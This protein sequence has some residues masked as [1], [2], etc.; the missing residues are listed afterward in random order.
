MGQ[1]EG[2]ASRRA[3]VEILELSVPSEQYLYILI[4]YHLPAS[5]FIRKSVYPI[6]LAPA[7]LSR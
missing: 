4:T 3:L 1:R 6:N 5:M 7:P 2:P